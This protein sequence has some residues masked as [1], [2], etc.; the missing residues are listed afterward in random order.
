MAISTMVTNFLQACSMRLLNQIEIIRG[1]LCGL[2]NAPKCVSGCPEP[3]Q[4]L[5]TL[6]QICQLAAEEDTRDTSH[7]PLP[8]ALDSSIFSTRHLA[9][10]AP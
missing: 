8:T 4:K 7:H 10:L 3:R 2:E 5:L 9:P 6:P 1:A